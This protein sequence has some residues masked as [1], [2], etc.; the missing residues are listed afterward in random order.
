[1]RARA[2]GPAGL[3]ERALN[4]W[5]ALQSLILDGWL[6][7]FADGYTKRANAACALPAGAGALA[8]AGAAIEDLYRRH[9]QTPIFRLTPFATPGDEAWLD[10]RGYERIEPTSVMLCGDPATHARPEP[11]LHIAATPDEAWLAGFVAGNRHGS[12]IRPTLTA[13]LAAIRSEAFY[14]TLLQD[15]APCGY[16]LAVIERGCVG[17]FDILVEARLRGRGFGRRLVAGM[18]DEALRRGAGTA[19][20]QV[21]ETNTAAIGL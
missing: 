17:L 20:L 14:A 3:E 5:P 2:P 6:V 15:G 13:M 4:A 16:G 9:G 7:R 10:A 18:L 21:L 11:G 8:P 1:M 12:G 19:Y